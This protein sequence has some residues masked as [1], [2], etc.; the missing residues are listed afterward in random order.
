MCS[1]SSGSRPAEL[2]RL[3]WRIGGGQRRLP[4]LARRA[5]RGGGRGPKPPFPPPPNPPRPLPNSLSLSPLALSLSFTRPPP[6]PC[7]AASAAAP[8][9]AAAAATAGREMTQA[10]GRG[11]R[12]HERMCIVTPV[13]TRSPGPVDWHDTDGPARQRFW[14]PGQGRPAKR[15][16]GGPAHS[17]LDV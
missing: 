6:V 17:A 7:E 10:A 14:P 5:R 8:A 12:A 9:P 1:T 3:A 2:G 4:P 16:T 11:P 15:A 13:W